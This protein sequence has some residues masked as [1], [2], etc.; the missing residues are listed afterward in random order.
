MS[1]SSDDSVSKMN[2]KKVLIISDIDNVIADTMSMV[3]I[4]IWGTWNV[5][6]PIERVTTSSVHKAVSNFFNEK[7]VFASPDASTIKKW[8]ELKCWTNPSFYQQIRPY[9]TYWGALLD[10]K[11]VGGKI[12]FLTSR[13][14]E[15]EKETRQW[16]D[17]Y[18]FE[19]A[20]L[21]TKKNGTKADTIDKVMRANPNFSF[22]Y[23]EDWIKDVASIAESTWHEAEVGRLRCW[24]RAHPWNQDSSPDWTE[25]DTKHLVERLEEDAI[26]RRIREG[27]AI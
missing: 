16:L 20:P 21:W 3:Q 1:A 19:N 12:L 14:E 9:P 7:L 11:Q 6:V 18:G 27:A 23:I 22:V 24:L 25:V 5:L 10:W 13:P 4:E 26:V 2:P 15:V 8:L 17:H